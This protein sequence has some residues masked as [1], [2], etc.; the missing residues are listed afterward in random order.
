MHWRVPR[1]GKLWEAAKG[2]PN[3]KAFKKLVETGTA[4]GILAFDSD[5]PVAWCSFGKRTDFPRLETAR[6]YRREDIQRVWSINCFFLVK[7]YRG[8]G[9]SYLLIKAA[10][11]A[12]RRRKGTLIEA[13]PVTLTKEGKQLP[14]VFSFTGPERIFQKLGFKEV[15]RLSASRPL[16]RLVCT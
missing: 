7:D 8:A 1:G 4:H 14:A 13:Y 6:A 16:Y 5:Q 12:I 11:K 3:R 2:K 9:L 15:Q 10:I